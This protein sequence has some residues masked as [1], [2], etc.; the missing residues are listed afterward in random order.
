M[1]QF[2]ILCIHVSRSLGGINMY[3][4]TDKDN[5]T[6]LLV[7]LTD[8]IQRLQPVL[9]G[10]IVAILKRNGVELIRDLVTRFEPIQL[11]KIDGLDI[12]EREKLEAVYFDLFRGAY[13]NLHG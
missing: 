9:G 1:G 6:L 8:D 2:S 7:D 13:E 10:S 3:K 4:I 5:Q 11:A 12:D